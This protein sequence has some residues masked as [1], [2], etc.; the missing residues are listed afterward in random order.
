MLNAMPPLRRIA[1]RHWSSCGAQVVCRLVAL[2][3]LVLA[4]A[5][6]AKAQEDEPR[7]P[8]EE[9]A[10]KL[11][12]LGEALDRSTV[13]GDHRQVARTLVALGKTHDALGDYRQSAASYARALSVWR[14]LND[15][16]EVAETLLVLGV[17]RKNLGDFPTAAG[18]LE[19]SLGYWQRLARHDR[20]AETSSLLALTYQRAGRFHEAARLYEQSLA[21]A[22]E[23]G[24]VE[25]EARVLNSLGGIARNLGEP[26]KELDYFERALELSRST[27]S[28]VGEGA[29]LNNLGALHDRLGE[30]ETALRYYAQAL[31]IFERLDHRYWQARTLNNIGYSYWILG[32]LERADAYLLRALELRREVGDRSGEAVTLL[33]L[34][35]TALASGRR[36]RAVAFFRRALDHSSSTANRRLVTTSRKLLGQASL[37]QGEPEAA[38]GVLELALAE[39]R[40]TGQRLPEAELLELL[41]RVHLALGQHDRAARRADEA[42]AL[43][44]ATRNPLGEVAT[45]ATL[46]RVRRAQGMT[47]GLDHLWTALDLLESFHGGLGDPSLRTSFL[48]SQRQVYE[49]GVELMMD[50]HRT[51]PAEG[52]HLEA[53]ALSERGRS[54][55]LL[56]LLEQAGAGLG[57]DV[58][59]G[60]RQRL[61]EAEQH[62]RAKTLYQLE[63]LGRPHAPQEATRA[64][65]ELYTALQ[66]LDN[67]R[68]ELRR[69]S[70][71]YAALDRSATLDSAGIQD[72]LDPGT[73]LLE[74][75][76]SEERSFLWW[77]TSTSVSVH[78][79]PSRGELETL[80]TEVHGQLSAP[81]GGQPAL[82]QNL[83]A[84]GDMVLGPV[85]D[86]LDGQRLVIVA[87]GALHAV[88]FAALTLPKGTPSGGS[89]LPLLAQHE[90]VSLPSASVLASQ[91]QRTPQSTPSKTIA[92]FADPIFDRLDPRLAQPPD[93]IGDESPGPAPRPRFA[94]LER[95]AHTRREAE[96]I[97]ALVPGD[98][99]LVAL[100]G[101]ARRSRLAGGD[102]R[103]YRVLHLATH[104]MADLRTPELSGL[105]LSRFDS[106]G[107]AVDG[108]LSLHDVS[109]LELS[110]ELV[111]LSACR[112]ALGKRVRGEGMMGLSRAFLHA[113]ASRVVASHWQVRDQAT[114]ELMTRFY[115]ALL[116]DGQRPAAALRTAQLGLRETRRFRDP[117]YWAA[118]TLQGDWR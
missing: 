38:R 64:E 47:T 11:E 24:E 21:L 89:G 18:L 97:A 111:V 104:G 84:L 48:A 75:L 109:N 25:L 15:D 60:L 107:R 49:L 62:F 26:A 81:P 19:E 53:L 66:T 106:E 16:T 112:T 2:S 42:L 67:V 27:G 30:S 59:P 5:S 54:R 34:G 115:R 87:D 6:P 14:E 94:G 50:L 9:G 74:Y 70:P 39:V 46:A 35:R 4:T 32:E 22:R 110:A 8:V 100:A 44:R 83:Q 41:S 116:E 68:A 10:A 114:T 76:L 102:L 96:V 80:A 29:V 20:L 13:L 88:P 79:L 118:F 98:R 113:G 55:S 3:M 103:D 101:D 108:F 86:R 36:G 28:A 117:A 73:V 12:R 72:L 33:N 52:H 1:Y 57:R 63:V 31:A 40:E 61:R 45:L 69:Q 95:L 43:H 71:H 93:G 7:T 77:V 17:A 78:E 56:T 90:V 23:L 51:S 105:V 65:Q 82:R 85:A 99:R 92:I 91:R 37:D 58:E